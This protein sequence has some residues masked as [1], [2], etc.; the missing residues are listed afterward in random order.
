AGPI[1]AGGQLQ[2]AYHER[3]AYWD[4][5][6]AQYKLIVL[7]AFHETADA[8]IAEQTLVE[9]RAAL[10]SQVL[11][12]ERSSNL[13]MARYEAGR[14]SYFEVLEALDQLFPAQSALA[15][16]QR[17]QL[18]AVVYLYKALGGGWNPATPQSPKAIVTAATTLVPARQGAPGK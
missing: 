10:E 2:A 15:A 18:L 1:Y 16:A 8:L 14:A 4:E 3:Q 6:V 11:A 5:T 17:D 13:A 7:R 12:L 9:R